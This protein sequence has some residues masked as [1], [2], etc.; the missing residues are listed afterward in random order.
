MKIRTHV[1]SGSL[2]WTIPPAIQKDQK[3]GAKR[4]AKRENKK[5]ATSDASDDGVDQNPFKERRTPG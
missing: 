4:E 1:R 2:A 5:E 3:D